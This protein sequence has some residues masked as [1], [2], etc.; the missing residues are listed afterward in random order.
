MSVVATNLAEPRGNETTI[1]HHKISIDV[2]EELP[3]CADAPVTEVIWSPLLVSLRQIVYAWR[4]ES[5]NAARNKL[6]DQGGIALVAYSSVADRTHDLWL[7]VVLL[8]Q[9]DSDLDVVVAG[10]ATVPPLEESWSAPMIMRILPW[11]NEQ[12]FWVCQGIQERFVWGWL[13]VTRKMKLTIQARQLR[14]RRVALRLPLDQYGDADTRESGK[15]AAERF[16]TTSNSLIEISQRK[17]HALS[18]G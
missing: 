7:R 18:R 12:R 1:V 16:G 9:E 8:H 11:G 6:S 13:K 3:E 15:A 17:D 10:E 4:I 5:H 2:D 14:P